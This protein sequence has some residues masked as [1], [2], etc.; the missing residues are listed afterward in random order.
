MKDAVTT[1]RAAGADQA[2]PS[3]PSEPGLHHYLVEA[4][5]GAV[6]AE[7]AAIFYLHLAALVG[8]AKLLPE[9]WLEEVA[10][11]ASRPWSRR[12]RGRPRERARQEEIEWHY[13]HRRLGG[14]KIPM[15]KPAVDIADIVQ[16]HKARGITITESAAKKMYQRAEKNYARRGHPYAVGRITVKQS[17]LD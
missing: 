5:E 10:D 11:L 1:K 9:S 2:Q 16:S 6:E 13:F 17:E 8:H 4:C 12:G 15:P 14:A 3:V 7:T